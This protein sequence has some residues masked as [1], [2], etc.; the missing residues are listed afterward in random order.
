MPSKEAF[1]GLFE[2]S[3]KLQPL[4]AVATLFSGKDHASFFQRDCFPNC[5]LNQLLTTCSLTTK[6]KIIN[7]GYQ[8]SSFSMHT[9]LAHV[10]FN[11]IRNKSDSSDRVTEQIQPMQWCISKTIERFVQEIHR[12][13]IHHR[14]GQ[15][16]LE[17]DDKTMRKRR[18]HECVGNIKTFE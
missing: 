6:K 4:K 17:N 16:Q 7:I 13:T 11:F 14:D 8:Q 10:R 12:R 3:S 1:R 5:F 9:T 15:R 2:T 18:M